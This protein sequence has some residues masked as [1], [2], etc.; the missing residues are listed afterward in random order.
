MAQIVIWYRFLLFEA[1]KQNS[2]FSKKHQLSPVAPPFFGR[3]RR[4]GLRRRESDRGREALRRAGLLARSS[5]R[6]GGTRRA[7]GWETNDG[8]KVLV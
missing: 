2:V 7:L 6:K 4:D 5:A 8:A 1:K 3:V